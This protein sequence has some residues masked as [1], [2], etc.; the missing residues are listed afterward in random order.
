MFGEGI[1]W[2]ITKE[3]G[4]R[5]EGVVASFAN[6]GKLMGA[7]QRVKMGKDSLITRE[8]PFLMKIA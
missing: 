4:L 6:P 5:T 7:E 3:R 1:F 2:D 8:E